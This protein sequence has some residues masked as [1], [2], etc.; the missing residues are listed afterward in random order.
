MIH[1]KLHSEKRVE[2]RFKSGSSDPS[3]C[4]LYLAQL[5]ICFGART[6]GPEQRKASEELMETVT[7][8]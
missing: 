7:G 3:F 2:R 8:Q 4:I 1:P 5:K 6:R